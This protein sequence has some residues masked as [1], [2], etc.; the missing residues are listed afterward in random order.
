[1][2]VHK[3]YV[4]RKQCVVPT[5][6]AKTSGLRYEPLWLLEES[7]EG[8]KVDFLACRTMA[9]GWALK[10]ITESRTIKALCL[11]PPK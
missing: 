9:C 8:F 3:G 1:V 11:I 10:D 5:G 4:K 6:R 7:S 2:E